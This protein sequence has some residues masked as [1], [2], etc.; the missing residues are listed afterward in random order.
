H[1]FKS[2]ARGEDEFL[3]PLM[4]NFASW[5]RHSAQENM[6]GN[7]EL[8]ETLRKVMPGFRELNLSESGEMCVH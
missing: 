6:G 3:E 7:Y 1:L 4:E 2:E 8:F 5:Y